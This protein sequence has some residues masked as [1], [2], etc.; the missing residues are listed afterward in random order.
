MQGLDP[1]DTRGVDGVEAWG[2]AAYVSSFQWAG[3]CC[4]LLGSTE[5]VGPPPASCLRW[6][7]PW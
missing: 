2:W 1:A 6:S 4:S 5:Y 7:L 3:A